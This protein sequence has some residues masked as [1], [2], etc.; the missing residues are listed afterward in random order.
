MK[1]KIA[2]PIRR[3]DFLGLTFQ[4]EINFSQVKARTIT[5][6]MLE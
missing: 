2:V 4:S 3:Q 6:M 5:L 1:G